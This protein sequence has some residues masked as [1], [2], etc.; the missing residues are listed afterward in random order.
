MRCAV[1]TRKS[2]EE[3]HAT[4]FGSIEAQRES[5]EA[6]VKSQRGL[7]WEPLP[8]RYDD[9]GFTGANVDRPAMERLL[10]DVEAGR[11]DVVV[12]YKI[13]RLSRSIGDF[14]GLTALFDRHSVS[15]VSVTQQF[16]TSTSAGR[17]TLNLLTVFAQFER[18]TIS[19]R[20]R[21]KMRAAR[22][23]GKYVGGGLLLGFD[24]HPEGR[25]LVVNEDEAQ[26]VRELFDLYLSLR[27]LVAVAREANARGWT[28]KSWVTRKGTTVLARRV[29][30]FYLVA[31][32]KNVAYV[33]KV[34][35]EGETIPAEHPAIVAQDTFDRVQALLAE[36]GSTGG[37]VGRTKHAAPLQGLLRCIPCDAPMGPC[38]TTR[39]GRLYRYYVCRKTREEGWAACPSK[40]VPAQEIERL[41]VEQ[42]QA[43]GKDADVQAQTLAAARAEQGGAELD[44]ADLARAL[45]LWDGV[46][47]VLRPKEQGRVLNLLL[48]RVGYDGAAGRVALTFRPSGIQALS[49]EVS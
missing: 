41:V 42:I 32:L 10:A 14:V 7:G 25:R 34:R 39:H 2:V 11:I 38:H 24:R 30:K 20:T 45:G 46:W 31:M 47:E 43:I 23:R 28:T 27:S 48:E 18:E 49:T 26:R 4:D 16:N 1:Y 19:E 3:R 21:D 15:F 44:T 40:S 35:F 36:N 17:L 33:G 6:F 9:E 13:D 29:N 12:V 37:R 5:C 22:R 8:Q